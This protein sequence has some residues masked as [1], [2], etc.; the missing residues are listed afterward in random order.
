MINSIENA[1]GIKI[2]KLKKLSGYDN[3][4]YLLVSGKS[5]YILKKYPFTKENHKLVTAENDCLQFLNKEDP[6]IYPKPVSGIEGSLTEI[7]SINKKKYVFRILSYIEGKFLGEVNHDKKLFNSLGS[8]LAKMNKLMIKYNNDAISSR[9]WEW[10]IQ[11]LHLNNKYIDDIPKAENKKLVL[12]F[13]QQFE[14]V[15]SPKLPYLRKSIIHNDANE[16][17]ILTNKGKV[18]GI[19]DYFSILGLEKIIIKWKL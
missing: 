8:F 10:D 18:T 3:E 2:D 1:F 4:N 17:N 19:I 14:E 5:K 15:V 7:L 6:S 12:Y 9:I 11:Y 16:W 13:F